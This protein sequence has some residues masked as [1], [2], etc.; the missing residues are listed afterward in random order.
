MASSCTPENQDG[1]PC[2][3][4]FPC[5]TRHSKQ[6]EKCNSERYF[7]AIGALMHLWSWRLGS[8]AVHFIF[9]STTAA[10]AIKSRDRV[11]AP[12]GAVTLQKLITHKKSDRK[13]AKCWAAPGKGRHILKSTTFFFSS[14]VFKSFPPRVLFRPRLAF[15]SLNFYQKCLVSCMRK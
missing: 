6:V 1:F 5:I 7:L 3:S 15:A 8:L 12:R 14:F 13:A 10:A 4:R 11:F 9:K 2:Q